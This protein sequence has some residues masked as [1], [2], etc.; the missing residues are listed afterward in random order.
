MKNRP[1]SSSLDGLGV[2]SCVV[3]LKLEEKALPKRWP[4]SKQYLLHGV[5]SLRVLPPPDS[6]LEFALVNRTKAKKIG[7]LLYFI[8]YRNP[9]LLYAWNYQKTFR[10]KTN[11]FSSSTKR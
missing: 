11:T 2:E 10:L 8:T 6:E 3:F 7:V 5:G 9:H 1:V 4:K